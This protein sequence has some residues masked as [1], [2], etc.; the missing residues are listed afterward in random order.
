MP[1]SAKHQEGLV[2]AAH[3][4]RFLVETDDG[5]LLPCF[6]RSRAGIVVCGDR[7]RIRHAGRGEGV[8]EAVEA[9]RSLIYRSDE[10]R[11]KPIAANVTQ[12]IVVTASAPRP[13]AEF[14]DRCLAAAEHAGVACLLVQN[15]VDLDPDGSLRTGL[16]QRYE[17]LG[18]RLLALSAHESVAPLVPLLG[19]Q[20]S[21]LIGQSGVGKSTI[22]NALVP[23]ANARTGEISRW[24]SGRHTTTH[25]QLYRLEGGGVVIDSPGMHQFGLQHIPP[26]ELAACFVEFRPFLGLCRFNDCRHDEE[27]GC[28]VRDAVDRGEIAAERLQ[29]YLRILAT[30]GEGR[31]PSGGRPE[32]ARQ[33]DE[34]DDEEP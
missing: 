14:I 31:L 17:A 24:N 27:P 23:D 16:L 33:R 8:I 7:V 5:T 32:P 1:A 6:A 15:K 4:R 2:V 18:Y 12:V 10:R 22:V 30:L 29:S 11:A 3:G 25:A 19:S 21:L 9:R 26:G 13:S 28:A 20:W 34:E